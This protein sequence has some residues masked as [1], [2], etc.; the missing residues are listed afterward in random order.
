MT[1]Q[2]AVDMEQLSAPRPAAW[3]DTHDRTS[4]EVSSPMK[5]SVQFPGATE[6]F[7]SLAADTSAERNRQLTKNVLE[8]ALDAEMTEYLGDDKHDRAGR[9][10]ATPATALGPRRC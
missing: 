1:I 10:A 5:R 4:S 8:T 9:A 3:A 7:V 6:Q 2:N